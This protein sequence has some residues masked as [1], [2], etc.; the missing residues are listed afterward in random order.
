MK[1]TGTEHRTASSMSKNLLRVKEE[2]MISDTTKELSEQGKHVV[3]IIHGPITQRLGDWL[4]PITFLWEADDEDPAYRAMIEKELQA[5]QREKMMDALKRDIKNLEHEIAEIKNYTPQNP[6][7]QV[8]QEKK[9][10]WKFL[11][12]CVVIAVA[13]GGLYIWTGSDLFS[14]IF[15]LLSIGLVF[16]TTYIL[17]KEEPT[18]EH[19]ETVRKRTIKEN[20]EM[21]RKK[22]NLY[23]YEKELLEKKEGL[24]K[25]MED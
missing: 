25:L 13:C 23:L 14:L 10:N 22:E 12:F 24:Q 8:N 15:S 2:V 16:G 18:E 11:M 4:A 7:V 9:S 1:I 6:E 21:E 17:I 19:L 5:K 3:N 20:K